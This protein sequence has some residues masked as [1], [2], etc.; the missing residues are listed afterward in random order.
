MA[1]LRNDGHGKFAAPETAP[2]AGGPTCVVPVDWNGDR[3]MDLV[4]TANNLDRVTVL[5]N[6]G[7]AVFKEALHVGFPR[8]KAW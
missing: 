1:I 8:V 2:C 5:I 7:N 4:F 6:E 3:K